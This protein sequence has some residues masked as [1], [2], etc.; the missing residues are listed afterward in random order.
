MSLYSDL[1]L[2]DSMKDQ[3]FRHKLQMLERK[4]TSGLEKIKSLIEEHVQNGLPVA[5]LLDKTKSFLT[6]RK[7][8][9]SHDGYSKYSRDILRLFPDAEEDLAPLCF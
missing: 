5:D 3:L 7:T 4:C 9:L 6:L 8:L 2:Q 1:S